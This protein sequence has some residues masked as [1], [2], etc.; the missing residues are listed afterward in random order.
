MSSQKVERLLTLLQVLL[1][2]PTPLTSQ[3]IRARVPGYSGDA[4]AFRRAFERDK[5][6]LADILG[7]PVRPEPIPGANP[8]VDGYRVRPEEAYLRDLGLSTEERRA[9]AVAASAV[10]LAGIDPGRGVA[11]LGEGTGGQPAAAA[12]TELPAGEAVVALFQAVAER[13]TAE[14]TYRD[15]PRTVHPLRLRFTKGRW[16]LTAFD[17][18]RDAER[19]FRL[20]RFESA[21]R[22]GPREGFAPRPVVADDVLDEPWAMGDGPA[23]EVRVR[24]DAERAEAA[25]RAAPRAG[26]VVAGDGTVVLTMGVRNVAALG[27]FVLGFVEAAE[28]LS[29]ADVRDEVVARLTALVGRFPTGRGAPSE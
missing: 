10:R 24:I 29:P 15:V 7:H 17:T 11:K 13:R 3:E 1:D 18:G 20:D 26:A 12:P 5:V 21:V 2:A 8:P 6:E 28:V 27:S 9:L 25:R 4:I 23:R 22:T 14:F 19:Q 16:Y